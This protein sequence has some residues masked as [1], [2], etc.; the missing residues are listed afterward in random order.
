VTITFPRAPRRVATAALA[1]L[2]LIPLAGC[3]GDDATS[4]AAGDGLA[5][6]APASS[7]FY[8]EAAIRPEGDLKADLDALVKKFAPGQDVG[9]LIDDALQGSSDDKVDYKRDIKPLLGE[10]AGFVITGLSAGAGDDLDGAGIIQTTDADKA[11]ATLR[12]DADGKIEDRSYDGVDYLFDSADELAAGIVADT[13]IVGT[14]PAF[15][16]IVDASKGEGLDTNAAYA[17]VVDAV[18][19]DALGYVY[20]DVR[21]AFDLAE[22]TAQGSA[23]AQQFEGVR[24]LLN[25]QGLKTFAASLAVTDTSVKIRAAAGTKDDGQG[26]APAETLAALPAG[27]WAA[28]GL[29]DL[30]KSLSDGLDSLKGLAGP[31]VN[32]QSGLDQLEQQSGID[33]QKDLISWLGQT[34]LF[35]RGTSLTDIGGALVVQSKDPTA[36]KTALAKARTLAAG[37]ELMAQDLTGKGIDDGFSIRFGNLPVEIFAALAGERFVLAVN[38][39][40][41]D[42]AINPAKKLEDDD[43]YKAATDLLGDGLKPSFFVDFPKVSGLINTFAGNEP[44]YAQVKPYLDKI[45]TIAAGSKREN[46]LQVQ[47]FAVGVR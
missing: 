33:V 11:L 9:K 35:V 3:G 29:G 25:R 20:G 46:D 40:A 34:G 13:L 39:P 42:E 44:G 16:A 30:G 23:N 6:L 8:L 37:A 10:R 15:K 14:D 38:R 31:G 43:A 21:R 24:E 12:K 7:P 45:T 47:T 22:R 1:G 19:E 36:T 41:L 5:R 4:L 27:S 2:A 17:K 32:V 28:L 18:D 26:D